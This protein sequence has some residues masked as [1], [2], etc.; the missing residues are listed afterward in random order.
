MD[1]LISIRKRQQW[2]AKTLFLCKFLLL[3]SLLTMTMT[4]FHY[5]KKVKNEFESS[6]N[7][8]LYRLWNLTDEYL[9]VFKIFIDSGR[10]RMIGVLTEVRT[11][12][13]CII[14]SKLPNLFNIQSQSDRI[15][16]CSSNHVLVYSVCTKFVLYSLHSQSSIL[17]SFHL[18]NKN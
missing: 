2:A 12:L 11:N 13:L 9:E 4:Y 10:I 14:F 7:L 8:A 17:I 18:V 1:I 6:R 16:G 15:A 5:L 3:I